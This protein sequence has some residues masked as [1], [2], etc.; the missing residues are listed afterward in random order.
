MSIAKQSKCQKRRATKITVI[1]LAGVIFAVL[2]SYIAFGQ[3]QS[4]HD[5]TIR[6][7]AILFR[8]GEKNPTSF[9][10]NDPHQNREWPGGPGALTARGSLQAFSLGQNL[11]LRYHSLLPTEGM[12]SQQNMFVRSSYAERCIMS[13]QAM[14]AGFMPPTESTSVLPFLWQPVPVT[15]VPRLDDT[16]IA[17][18]KP[19]LKYDKMMKEIYSNPPPDLAQL[20]ADNLELYHN[21]TEFTGK[22]IKT[23]L[24]VEFLYNTLKAEEDMGLQ[25]PQWTVGVYPDRLVPLAEKSYTLFTDND[26]MKRIRG[27][28]FVGEV[29]NKMAA[30]VNKT[31]ESSRNLFFYSGHDV[32][33]VNVMNSMGILNQTSTLPDFSSALVFELHEMSNL[34]EQYEVKVVYY[35]DSKT[36][37]PNVINVLNCPTPCDL[38]SFK[39]SMSGLLFDSYDEVCEN[40]EKC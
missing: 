1:V 23:V 24:D 6:M 15:S 27:G 22:P 3:K 37:N 8:H 35:Q 21:L 26:Y 17:Q 19:C 33:L 18:K 9:Y 38:E 7:A 16:L 20:D 34:P 4:L 2:T 39:K 31:L 36:D 40:P 11:R 13:A 28:A 14:L 30:K 5:S 10:P 29:Y 32:T 12:Y 25:L